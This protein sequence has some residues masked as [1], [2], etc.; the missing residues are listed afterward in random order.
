MP[1]LLSLASPRL[2]GC[3]D[4]GEEPRS[5]MSTRTTTAHRPCHAAAPLSKGVLGPHWKD[6]RRPAHELPSEWDLY[7]G[8]DGVAGLVYL[9]V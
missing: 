4:R 7:A 2:C 6:L 8:P 5:A 9:A 3:A 1:P